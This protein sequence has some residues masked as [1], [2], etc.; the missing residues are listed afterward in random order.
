MGT[1]V[2]FLVLTLLVA[3]VLVLVDE[4]VT[5]ARERE[6]RH[7]QEQQLAAM[8]QTKE[9]AAQRIRHLNRAYREELT[10]AMSARSRTPRRRTR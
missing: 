8:R 5:A 10:Q 1:L 7:R 4:A 3:I 6:E 2:V 9:V